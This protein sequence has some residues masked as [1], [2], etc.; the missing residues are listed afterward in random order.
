MR[1]ELPDPPSWRTSASGGRSR[2]PPGPIGIDS[3]STGG[4][5]FPADA[6]VLAAAERADNLAWALEEMADSAS[7]GRPIGCKSR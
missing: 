2:S 6:A 4:A 3:L 5:D 7:G 1:D